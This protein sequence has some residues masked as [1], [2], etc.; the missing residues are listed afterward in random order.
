MFRVNVTELK[1]RSFYSV[2]LGN[3]AFTLSPTVLTGPF[4]HASY[5]LATVGIA[6]SR[7]PA[8]TSLSNC[9]D[10]LPADANISTVTALLVSCQLPAIYGFFVLLQISLGSLL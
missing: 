3:C 9:I 7:I 8:V 1:G 2:F 10:A 5:Y 4:A 6:R